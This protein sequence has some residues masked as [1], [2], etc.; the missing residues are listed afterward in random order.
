[1]APRILVFN[2]HEAWVHQLEGI[3]FE[4]DII[5]DLPGRFK[6]GWDESM[7]PVPRGAR[8]LPF[9]ELATADLRPHVVV[10]H[11][12]T[13]L[14]DVK[15]LDAPKLVVL[16]TT[17]EGR[18]IETGSFVEPAELRASLRGFLDLIGG[19]AVATSNLKGRSWGNTEDVVPFSADVAQYPEPTLE[20]A[21]GIR[22]SNH[23]RKR[24]IILRADFHDRAF[25]RVPVRIVG[26][27]PDLPD[28]RAASSWQELREL[29]AR[30][31]FFVHTAHPELEDGYN[32]ATL[33]A[34]AAGLPVLGNRHPTSPIEHGVSGFLSDNPE[35]LAGYAE[36]LI[37]DRDLAQKLGSAAREHVR[38][39]FSLARFHER[40]RRS[41]DTA[42]AKFT[43]RAA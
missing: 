43:A 23:F 21:Q 42:R 37:A 28:A 40:F 10:A 5:V 3:G 26:H 15:H 27:N 4:L 34:M 35:E 31:R 25:A 19:H 22:I 17:I 24:S 18:I 16:H 30:H 20:L 33:E 6:G 9:S 39:H 14:L 1:M 13:D 8:L 41:I 38:E 36:L 11:G 32:M 12:I 7:R 2:C 29:L